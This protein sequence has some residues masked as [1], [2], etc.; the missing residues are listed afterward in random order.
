MQADIRRILQ[1]EI[2]LARQLFVL[3][4]DANV[5][6]VMVALTLAKVVTGPSLA[7]TR[8]PYVPAAPGVAEVARDPGVSIVSAMGP[9]SALQL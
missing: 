3:A 1:A 9:L 5:W 7:L 6:P 2:V 4:Q 8:R